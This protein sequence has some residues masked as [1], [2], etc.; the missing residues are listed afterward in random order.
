MDIWGKH[1][2]IIIGIFTVEVYLKRLYSSWKTTL[3]TVQNLRLK[4]S[5]LQQTVQGLCLWMAP[6][7]THGIL[8]VR[9][10]YLSSSCGESCLARKRN[11]REQMNLLNTRSRNV[12]IRNLL[13]SCLR[14]LHLWHRH[15][16]WPIYDNK[17]VES[18]SC[19]IKVRVCY[20]LVQ[21][22]R[23]F[24]RLWAQATID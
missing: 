23:N 16:C 12:K 22:L 3:M 9:W 13:Q 8:S 15:V 19:S 5:W 7:T 17:H 6:T 4:S 14:F 20:F 11:Q 2:N 1:R 21:S 10:L 18:P 24:N